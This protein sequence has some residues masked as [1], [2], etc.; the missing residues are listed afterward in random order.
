VFVEE[1]PSPKLARIENRNLLYPIPCVET[2]KPF[3]RK[4]RKRKKKKNDKTDV[5]HVCPYPTGASK[6]KKFL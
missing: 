5:T 2:R 3:H 4:K 1:E 6:T